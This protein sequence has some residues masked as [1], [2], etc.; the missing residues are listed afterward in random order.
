MA[1]LATPLRSLA[2]GDDLGQFIDEESNGR[3]GRLADDTGDGGSVELRLNHFVNG[4]DVR[5]G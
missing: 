2:P 3:E 5:G 1:M 4:G